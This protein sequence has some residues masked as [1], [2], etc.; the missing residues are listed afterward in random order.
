MLVFMI[1][2]INSNQLRF[3]LAK[4]AKNYL[5]EGEIKNIDFLLTVKK[6]FNLSPA[7]WPSPP[8]FLYSTKCLTL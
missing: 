2:D 5:R 7:L 4:M 3:D 8:P 6:V 1:S